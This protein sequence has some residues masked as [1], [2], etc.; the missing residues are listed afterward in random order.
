MTG[1]VSARPEATVL[2]VDDD[3]SMRDAIGSLVRSVGL[4]LETFATARDFMRR[5]KTEGPACMVLDVRLPGLSGL[6]LQRELAAANQTT[7]IIFITGYG[8]IPMSVTAM[9]AGA[10][11][12]LPKP[13]RAQDLL[14][15]IQQAIAQDTAAFLR[16]AEIAALR[17]RYENLTPRE[18]EVMALAAAGLL[19]KHIADH[20]GTS[21]ITVKLQRSEVMRKLAAATVVDLARMAEKLGLAV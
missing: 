16:R 7:P 14:D 10:V 15:A 20:L 3:A 6:E 12:F 1:P 17:A 2:V 11:E 4:R 18:R 9:K 19:N 8:D 13:F 21:E 5:K